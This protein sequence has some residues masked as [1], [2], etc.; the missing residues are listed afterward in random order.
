MPKFLPASVYPDLPTVEF[1]HPAAFDIVKVQDGWVVFEFVSG[2][3]L[4]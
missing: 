4:C 3:G 2:A 1:H